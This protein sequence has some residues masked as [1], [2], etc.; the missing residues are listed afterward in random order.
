MINSEPLEW[1]SDLWRCV[2]ARDKV[3]EWFALEVMVETFDELSKVG[4]DR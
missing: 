1:S 2:N 3:K 4:H